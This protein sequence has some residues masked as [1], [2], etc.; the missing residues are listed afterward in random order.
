[1]MLYLGKF[2]LEC[3][4]I[5]LANRYFCSLKAII[6]KSASNSFKLRMQLAKL[7][8]STGKYQE[9]IMEVHAAASLSP[10]DVE[11]ATQVN[12]SLS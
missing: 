6:S 9:A 2:T 8:T 3:L 5:L 4:E 11:E 1:M 10:K 7:L 12:H